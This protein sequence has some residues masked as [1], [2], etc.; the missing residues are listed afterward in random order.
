MQEIVGAPPYNLCVASIYTT[1][2]HDWHLLHRPRLA[3]VEFLA[4]LAGSP[5]AR[6][7][8]V[9]AGSGDIAALLQQRG[10]E[11]YAIDVNHEMC[12]VARARHPQL[13]VVHGD[14]LEVFD[15][16]RGPLALA[17]CLGGGLCELGHVDE[18]RDVIAQLCDLARPA[19][20]VV[21]EVP[22]FDHLRLEAQRVCDE[23]AQVA[24]GDVRFGDLEDTPP[25]HGSANYGSVSAGEL[26]LYLPAV[27]G[28][29]EDGSELRLEQDYVWPKGGDG[30][31]LAWRFT[32]PEGE[33]SGEL[34]LLEL[35]RDALASSI[36]TGSDVAWYGDWDGR[37]WSPSGGT[38][39]AVIRNR[40][41]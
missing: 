26:R 35:T 24:P 29:R 40:A 30:P 22:N 13:N 16:V 34:A 31:L 38:S 23:A 8:D 39:I 1:L 5:P 2:A 36:P 17:C 25:T 19:G 15:L 10:F 4:Q 20:C 21:L 33:S 41:V 37:E 7:A 32:A 28:Y 27:S 11:A 6:I 3:A 14:M 9:A 18:V 12:S